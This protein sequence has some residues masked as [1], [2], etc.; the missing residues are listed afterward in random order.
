MS[1]FVFALV[2]FPAVAVTLTVMPLPSPVVRALESWNFS[3]QFADV[4]CSVIE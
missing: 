1:S 4:E 2:P 3:P